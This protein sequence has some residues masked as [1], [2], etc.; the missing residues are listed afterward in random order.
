MY[1]PIMVDKHAYAGEE[2]LT[3]SDSQI[4]ETFQFKKVAI[5]KT[6][7]DSVEGT[8]NNFMISG[9]TPLFI[10]K[11]LNHDSSDEGCVGFILNEGTEINLLGIQHISICE[12]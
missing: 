8:V 12:T 3:M 11:R 10:R 6:N 2:L 4:R 9:P 5:T 1:A 7:G